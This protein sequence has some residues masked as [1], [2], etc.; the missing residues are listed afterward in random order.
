[1]T[2]KCATMCLA[3]CQGLCTQRPIL[4]SPKSH[5]IILLFLLQKQQ[6]L[7]GLQ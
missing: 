6:H 2:S 7:G 1:M 5:E 3:P 4:S